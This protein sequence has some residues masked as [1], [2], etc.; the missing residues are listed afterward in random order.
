MNPSANNIP[1]EED[2]ELINAYTRNPLATEQVY[3]FTL[4]LCDNEIDRDYE[5]FS[6]DA[7]NSLIPLFAGKTGIAD[8]NMSS[9]NQKARIF[10][11][12]LEE[13]STKK[14]SAGE[15]YTALRAKAYMLITEESKEMI[16]QIEG[17]IKKEVSVGCSMGSMICSICG[18]DMKHHECKHIKGKHYGK[19]LCHGILSDARDAYEWSFV[20]V[21]AQKNAGVTKAFTCRRTEKAPA[22]ATFTCNEDEDVY[23][24]KYVD[25]LEKQAEQGELYREYLIS[26]I[27][28]YALIA[29]NRVCIDTFI[30]G[31]SGSD[32]RSLKSLMDSLRAQAN[33]IIPVSLQLKGAVT[34]K[35]NSNNNSFKI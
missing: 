20:A 2:L 19:K 24:R 15:S 5:R 35:T 14:T 31:C 6:V 8:H 18:K 29:M 28:K 21:P 11:T 12:W 23:S 25:M 34:G 10:K 4:T 1:T 33:E 30:D 9:S 16:E 3:C 13:D 17:G 22:E 32:V 27:R 7:L 26:Q